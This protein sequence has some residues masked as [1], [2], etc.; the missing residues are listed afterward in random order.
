MLPTDSMFRRSPAP[1]RF[2]SGLDP[3]AP[4]WGDRKIR[5]DGQVED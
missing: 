5:H 4:T 3:E 2:G 1:S